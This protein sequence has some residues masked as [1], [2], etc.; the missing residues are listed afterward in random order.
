[1]SAYGA[2]V[3]AAEAAGWWPD[4]AGLEHDEEL[5][6]PDPAAMHAASERNRAFTTYSRLLAGVS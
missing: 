5:T 6:A 3:L 2:A 4:A 1:G